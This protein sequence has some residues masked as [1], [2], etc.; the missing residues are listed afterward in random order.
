MVCH[1]LNHKQLT[2]DPVSCFFCKPQW[3]KFL[4]TLR[5]YWC[6]SSASALWFLHLRLFRFSHHLSFIIGKTLSRQRQQITERDLLSAFQNHDLP[7]SINFADRP[8][9]N[10]VISALFFSRLAGTR[11]PSPLD[12]DPAI[13]PT[14]GAACP[15]PPGHLYPALFAAWSTAPPPEGPHRTHSRLQREKTRRPVMAGHLRV[16]CRD[17][18]GQEEHVVVFL[19]HAWCPRSSDFS[20]GWW[21]HPPARSLQNSVL[22]ESPLDIQHGA[23]DLFLLHLLCLLPAFPLLHGLIVHKQVHLLTGICFRHFPP[24]STLSW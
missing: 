11:S 7:I 15:V 2:G 16:D 13:R 3:S 22:A 5:T 4:L 14:H 19:S 17:I 23:L 20:L 8:G 10:Q 12:A 24:G 1:P 9:G 21:P 6:S 18:M